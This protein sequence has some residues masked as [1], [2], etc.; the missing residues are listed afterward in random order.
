MPLPGDSFTGPDLQRAGTLDCAVEACFECVRDYV[1]RS[2][3]GVGNLLMGS[4]R[5]TLNE[6]DRST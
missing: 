1:R 4:V 2:L 3:D 6:I 5:N